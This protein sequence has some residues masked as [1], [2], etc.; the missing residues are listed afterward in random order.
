[1][2]QPKKEKDFTW[3]DMKRVVNR[4]PPDLLKLKVYIWP[5]EEERAL[6]VTGI[7]RLREDYVYD[8]DVA[9]CPKSIMKA[10]D[11]Q[12]WKEKKDEYYVV[13]PKGTRI[14]NAE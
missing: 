12:D 1:M 10:G 2:K 5:D 4:M 7:N 8:G 11:P 9:C 6:V 14:I 3:A 13:H